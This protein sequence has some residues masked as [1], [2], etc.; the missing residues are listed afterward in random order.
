MLCRVLLSYPLLCLFLTGLLFQQSLLK[1]Y[2]AQASSGAVLGRALRGEGAPAIHCEVDC[3]LCL[4]RM[5]SPP[6]ESTE[7]SRRCRMRVVTGQ[8]H[9]GPQGR[10]TGNR[11]LKQ[12]TGDCATANS[13]GYWEQKRSWAKGQG[14][15]YAQ[16]LAFL[17]RVFLHLALVFKAQC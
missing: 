10:W 5:G 9:K 1:C 17:G 2:S 6:K 3:L 13:T 15:T 14:A 8:W 16:G 7:T 11:N 4:A 12:E